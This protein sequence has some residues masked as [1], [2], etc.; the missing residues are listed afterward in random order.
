MIRFK[1]KDIYEANLRNGYTLLPF[2][3]TR[4]RGNEYVATNLAG[5]YV[6]LNRNTIQKLVDLGLD[7]DSEEYKTLKV[8]HFLIDEDSGIAP[9]LLALKW[10]TKLAG[11]SDF[12][13][14]HM[15]VVTLRCE[16]SCPY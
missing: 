8:K 2:K 4:L 7:S 3:F 14:L 10:R 5:E 11:L 13:S 9:E 16:H 15:M 12:T 1:H 6:I